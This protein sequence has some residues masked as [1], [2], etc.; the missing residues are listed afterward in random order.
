MRFL[1]EIERASRLRCAL[2]EAREASKTAKLKSVSFRVH[3][4]VGS[5]RSGSDIN[6]ER[7]FKFHPKPPTPPRKPK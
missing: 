7:G 6:F 3:R 5:N 2:H 4:S 1:D